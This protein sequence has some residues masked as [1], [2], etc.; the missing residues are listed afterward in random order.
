[1][2]RGQL[3]VGWPS[4]PIPYGCAIGSRPYGLAAHYRGLGHSRLPIAASHGQPLLLA[5]LVTN[6]LN[7]STGWKENKRWWLKL[8]DTEL[9]VS[10]SHQNAL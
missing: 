8:S 10:H 9:A 4:A 1:M 7:D 2:R 3:L 6:A 5:V